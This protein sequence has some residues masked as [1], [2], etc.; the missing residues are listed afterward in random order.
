MSLNVRCT[1]T[2]GDLANDLVAITRRSTGDMRKVVRDN[3][4][5]GN[6]LARAN[7]KRTAGSHGKHYHRAFSWEMT[8]LTVGEYGPDASKPQ[9]GMSFEG[10]SR[11]QPPHNDLA[12][13]ADIQGPLFARDAGKLADEW[14]W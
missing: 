1:H 8:G 7:A 14:F 11:N 2:V 9:G 3:L 6:R 12:K 5:A 4:A 13:S 10:G